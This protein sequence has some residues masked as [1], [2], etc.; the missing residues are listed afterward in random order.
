MGIDAV[1]ARRERG[2]KPAVDDQRRAVEDDGEVRRNRLTLK[3]VACNPLCWL[4]ALI[5]TQWAEPNVLPIP[6]VDSRECAQ[7][8]SQRYLRFTQDAEK[9][10]TKLT[11]GREEIE[12]MCAGGRGPGR[13]R[14]RVRLVLG[15]GRGVST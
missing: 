7:E 10:Y 9:P 11:K 2:T 12:A 14:R 15:E 13:P 3:A 8:K 1:V 5:A 6:W 4:V